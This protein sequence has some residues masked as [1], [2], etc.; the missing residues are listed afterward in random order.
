MC[1]KKEK[2]SLIVLF[3]QPQVLSTQDGGEFINM[4]NWIINSQLWS[5]FVRFKDKFSPV[6]GLPVK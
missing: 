1:T 6:S 5:F 3:S 4:E 2:V